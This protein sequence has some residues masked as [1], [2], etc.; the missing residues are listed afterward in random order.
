MSPVVEGL[1]IRR[2]GW[3]AHD[4]VLCRSLQWL[5]AFDALFMH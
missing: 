5:V 3:R 4:R 2:R 1:E